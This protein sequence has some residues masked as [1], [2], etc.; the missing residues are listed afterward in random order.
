MRLLDQV[1]Q[2]RSSVRVTPN[3]DPSFAMELTAARDFADAIIACP[4]RYVLNDDLT[5]ASAELA[6]SDG[7]RLAGCLD[8]VR[9]PASGLWVEWNDAIH[10]QVVCES[11]SS[12]NPDPDA[13]GRRVGVLL[14]ATP[15]GQQGVARTFCSASSVTDQNE[16]VLSPI[17]TH[18]DLR[19][20]FAAGED[21]EAVLSG[22][23]ASVSDEVDAGVDAL[24]ECV[25]FRF[26][27]RWS[28]YYR[29]AAIT[30][31][32]KRTAVHDSLAAVA[33]DA[34]FL[35]AFFLLLNAR[36]ATRALTIDR[37]G[38]N[39]KRS[40]IGRAP[41]LDHI[42][43]HSSINS[44]R[45]T[46]PLSESAEGTKRPLRLHHVRGHIVRRANSIFWRIPHLRGRA[47]A[48]IVRSRSV[49]LSF[50][51]P[52]SSVRRTDIASES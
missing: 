47:S 6:F 2:S 4:L 14:R 33:R 10:Q 44:M 25:R 51:H 7:D 23:F 45:S 26:D 18:F 29:A 9:I 28:R 24:L 37:R 15:S 32:Q 52:T 42:E 41:L 20:E 8:L 35:I 22:A 11:G 19:G 12:A 30:S 38:I 43:V 36:D 3:G 31:E 17:E 50:E 16:V 39:R 13:Q 49:C 5:R 46:P 48:G 40:S 21:V 27:D 34:P 1:S